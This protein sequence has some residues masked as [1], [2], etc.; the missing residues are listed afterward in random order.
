MSQYP[1]SLAAALDNP[2]EPGQTTPSYGGAVGGHEFDVPIDQPSY[3]RQYSNTPPRRPS[4]PN[5]QRNVLQ[6]DATM[7]QPL[8]Q[9][10]PRQMAQHRPRPASMPPNAYAPPVP[11]SASYERDRRPPEDPNKPQ[12]SASRSRTTN[13]ILGDYTLSKTLGAGSM[14]KV[15]L[16]THNVTGEKV[17]SVLG[18]TWCHLLNI[19]DLHS[20]L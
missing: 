14:G 16:A 3:H 18:A 5:E 12:R 20:L 11:P 15:K 7:P 9:A 2:T 6:N 1:T 10:Q 19:F 4:N 8:T 17:C 13:R